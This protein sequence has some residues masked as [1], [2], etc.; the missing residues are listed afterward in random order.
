MKKRSRRSCWKPKEE[1][2]EDEKN[3]TGFQE[4]SIAIVKAVSW[5]MLLF[6]YGQYF[7]VRIGWRMALNM[8]T[9]LLLK[10]WKV[11]WLLSLT[12]RH[13]SRSRR[14]ENG[15]KVWRL[16]YM[17][18]WI[19]ILNHVLFCYCCRWKCSKWLH[20]NIIWFYWMR[21]HTH[22]NRASSKSEWVIKKFRSNHAWTPF[23]F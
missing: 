4:S 13:R 9:K 7:H 22:F 19:F 18:N 8:V 3:A 14:E 1:E 2:E 20:F 15:E 23:F 10:Q 16:R 6:I 17:Y 21:S 5:S 12:Q 11:A